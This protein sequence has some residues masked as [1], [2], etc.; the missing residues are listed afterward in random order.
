MAALN[1]AD[2]GAPLSIMSANLISAMRTG[3]VPGVAVRYLSRE[4]AST[5]GIVGCGVINRACAKAILS[6]LPHLKKVYLFDIVSDAAKKFASEMQAK[7]DVEYIV[8]NNL[9]EAI[10]DS[11]VISIAASGTQKVAVE[12]SWLKPGSLFTMTGTCQLPDECFIKNKVV[13]DHWPMHKVWYEEGLMHKDGLESVAEW[14]PSYQ[15]LKLLHFGRI[16]E[17]DAMSLGEV[18]IGNVK[19][20]N[21]DDDVVIFIS[22]GL[23]V[24][25][26]S[27]GYAVYE[28][29]LARDIGQK[30]VLW[31]EAHWA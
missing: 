27:W 4:H 13:Y 19:G 7:F 3:A 18:A 15:L 2:T 10:T 26:V 29:A 25:D 17:K 11:D 12:K 9:K 5:V 16:S 28:E 23:P 24:E 1:D 22:G 30:L 20:R 21:S 6:N 31:E 14:A 8:V